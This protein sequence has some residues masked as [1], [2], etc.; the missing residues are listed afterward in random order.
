MA[1]LRAPT[2]GPGPARDA[3]PAEGGMEGRHGVGATR[4]TVSTIGA[5]IALAGVEHGIGEILQGDVAP[6]GTIIESWPG[7]EPFRVLAGE[8]AMTVVPNL[9][10]TGVLAVLSSLL[11]LVVATA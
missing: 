10:A 5:L 7:S 6:A 9:L 4:L 1:T 3:P 2:A 8:P 11:L